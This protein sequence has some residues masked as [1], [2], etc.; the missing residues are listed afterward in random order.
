VNC[1]REK[2]DEEVF[3][4]YDLEVL[5]LKEGE[6][7]L[8]EYYTIS[9]HGIVHV[10]TEKYKKDHGD[11]STEFV[12][13][14]EWMHESTMFNI[15]T[16][17]PFFK[18]F[19]I[20]KI[21]SIWRLNV[22]YRV[23]CKRRKE[24]V[25]KVFYSKPQFSKNLLDINKHMHDIQSYKTVQIQ[26]QNNYEI[27]L[28]K[29]NQQTYRN[30][31]QKHYDKVGENIAAIM[32]GVKK[33]VSESRNLKL[34][35]EL[36][37]NKIGKQTR[38][39]PMVQIK[40][41]KLEREQRRTLAIRDENMLS[42]F[43]RLVDYI[44]IE[45]LISVSHNSMY[46]FLEEMNRPRGKGLFV[47]LV[48]FGDAQKEPGAMTYSPPEDELQQ[49]LESN[50]EEMIGTVSI[51]RIIDHPN[52]ESLMKN[53]NRPEIKSIIKESRE[54]KDVS[55]KIRDRISYSF[56]LA[57][58]HVEN[59]YESCREIY[60]F[61][62]TWDFATW[63]Q[64][65]HTPDEVNQFD[66]KLRHWIK[67]LDNMRDVELGVLYVEGSKQK[68]RLLNDISD[69]ILNQKLRAYYQKQIKE[70]GERVQKELGEVKSRLQTKPEK[71]NEF[72]SFVEF[73]TEVSN[74]KKYYMESVDDLNTFHKRLKEID[75]ISG[76]GVTEHRI[77]TEAKEIA[78]KLEDL[79]F[80]ASTYRKDKNQA[81]EELLTKDEENIQQ[82]ITI[83]LEKI[84]DKELIDVSTPSNIAI[85]TLNQIRNQ[86]ERFKS[87]TKA[88]SQQHLVKYF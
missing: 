3:R 32:D 5:P 15:I 72:A 40:K 38:Q 6:I 85:Q 52:Y 22:R 75:P 23:Y 11:A 84:N 48:Y 43:I 74:N 56:K 2:T 8:N 61:T 63:E 81:M 20:G 49:K 26:P 78:E 21:F 37:E 14:S 28:F 41:E 55:T 7:T 60:D 82:G 87:Q 13:L 58:E 50:L 76:I 17:L 1:V 45:N 83:N 36:D 47:T 44:M 73:I 29:S 69:T 59:K 57:R 66:L 30:E 12:S 34:P 70:R 53:R 67:E 42:E 39:K 24:L 64:T 27:E 46:Y 16:K 19:I 62:N 31:A 33:Q 18:N 25:N 88:W 71:V 10:F 9:A 35:S 65:P 51:A 80:E 77:L 4:P 54:F 86:I 79:L 68:K